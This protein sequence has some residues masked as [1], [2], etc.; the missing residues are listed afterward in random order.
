M[1]ALTG[2]IAVTPHA[3]W[4]A[5][6]PDRAVIQIDPNTLRVTRTIGLGS[7]PYRLSAGDGALWIAE[8]YDGTLRRFD[9]ANRLLSRPFR[10]QPRSRGRSRLHTAPDRSG[11]APKT[12]SSR[13]WSPA[14]VGL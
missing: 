9:L 4:V 8:G 2:S 7:I 3:V 13:D 12:T 11:S 5:D 6:G 14:P 1:P 10:P